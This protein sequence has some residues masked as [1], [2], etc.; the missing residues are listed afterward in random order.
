MD[1]QWND[2]KGY[3]QKAKPVEYKIK[4]PVFESIAMTPES[5]HD[6]EG[7]KHATFEME[8][9]PSTVFHMA[10]VYYN[11]GNNH[12][13]WHYEL[14]E[15]DQWFANSITALIQAACDYFHASDDDYEPMQG[16]EGIVI[17]DEA[18]IE[19]IR[20]IDLGENFREADR[21]NRKRYPLQELPFEQ[22]R[23][24]VEQI[25][26][27]KQFVG[28]EFV[29]EVVPAAA[30]TPADKPVMTR[31]DEYSMYDLE[32]GHVFDTRDYPEWYR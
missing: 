25:E 26:A 17:S 11:H 27:L 29:G 28:F 6:C 7:G 22:Q 4:V 5:L 18:V 2:P 19:R 3:D 20:R 12:A 1:N 31:P 14:A 24:L 13:G 23:A 32:S 10:R 30:P 9:S 16:V 15:A 8:L 21:T